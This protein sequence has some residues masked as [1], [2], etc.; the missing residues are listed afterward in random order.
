VI[1]MKRGIKAHHWEFGDMPRVEGV[2][3][4]DVAMIISYVRQLQKEAGIF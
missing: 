1:E 3:K 2:K 4:E